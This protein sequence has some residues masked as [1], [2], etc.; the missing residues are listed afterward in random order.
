V[1][2]ISLRSPDNKFKAAACEF[3]HAVVIFMIGKA[4]TKPDIIKIN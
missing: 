3:I 1:L 4:A 2:D